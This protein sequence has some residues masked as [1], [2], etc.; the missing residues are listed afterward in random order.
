MIRVRGQ[1][2]DSDGLCDSLFFF[3]RRKTLSKSDSNKLCNWKGIMGRAWEMR[4][5][6]VKR[7]KREKKER[8]REPETENGEH[9]CR[10]SEE[11]AKRKSRK[12]A[13]VNSLRANMRDTAMEFRIKK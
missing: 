13:I 8:D 4:E 3:F 12:S 9:D 5:V 7:E 2:V 1:C 11:R 6:R 10:K